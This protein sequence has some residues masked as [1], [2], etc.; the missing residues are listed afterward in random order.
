MP[1]G[2]A[3]GS[4]AFM[5]F[6]DRIPGGVEVGSPFLLKGSVIIP[7]IYRNVRRTRNLALFELPFPDNDTVG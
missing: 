7:P 3:K 6:A 5:R 4:M 2:P 1:T